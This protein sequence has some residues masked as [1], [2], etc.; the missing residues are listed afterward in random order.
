MMGFIDRSKF[1]KHCGLKRESWAEH[2]RENK[3]LPYVR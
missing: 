1:N 2:G 3:E